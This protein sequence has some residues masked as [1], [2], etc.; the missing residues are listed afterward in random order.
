[1]SLGGWR[2]WDVAV[3]HWVGG[4]TG[5]W[6]CVTGWVATLECC[7]VSLG[8]WR[9]WDVGGVSLGGW[10]HWDVAVCHWVSGDIGYAVAQLVEALRYNPEGLGL[11]FRW[12]HWNS[13]L[14]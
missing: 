4:D 10:R 5:M 11:D 3:C 2:H 12:R 1:M 6:R 7:S 13:L 9:H 14:T 8:G